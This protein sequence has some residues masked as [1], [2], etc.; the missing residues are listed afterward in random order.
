MIIVDIISVAFVTGVAFVVGFMF[1]YSA[2][3][4]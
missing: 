4:R 1:G 2:E 3:R